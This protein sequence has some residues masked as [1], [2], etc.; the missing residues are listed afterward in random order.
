[1]VDATS[2]FVEAASVDPISAALLLVGNLILAVS[3]GIGAYLTVGAIVGA[4]RH[5]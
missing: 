3:I 1:M 5:P 4:L 2:Y